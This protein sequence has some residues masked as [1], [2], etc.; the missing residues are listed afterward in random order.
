MHTEHSIKLITYIGGPR[1]TQG[2]R[3]TPSTVENL[4][5]TFDSAQNLLIDYC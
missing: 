3:I 2:L 5:V 4:H 1:I